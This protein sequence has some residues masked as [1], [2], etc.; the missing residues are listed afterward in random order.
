M[1]NGNPFD[2]LNIQDF[3]LNAIK[4]AVFI[5]DEQT[6]RTHLSSL[7]SSMYFKCKLHVEGTHMFAYDQKSAKWIETTSNNKKIAEGDISGLSTA[8]ISHLRYQKGYI[9]CVVNGEVEEERLDGD[10]MWM[11][12]AMY[13]LRHSI[14]E[15]TPHTYAKVMILI[16]Y[17]ITQAGRLQ[18]S[19]TKIVAWLQGMKRGIECAFIGCTK[20]DTLTTK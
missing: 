2:E 15:I 4:K 17:L 11:H 8:L 13:Y 19:A 16:E 10:E 5:I 14:P 12:R 18:N 6:F 3:T 1:M 20:R 7:H 9:R